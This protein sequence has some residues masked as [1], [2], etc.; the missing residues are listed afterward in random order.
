[1]SGPANGS[2]GVL[3]TNTGAVTYS[4]SNNFNGADSF[5]FTVFDGTL[6]ATGTVSLL[7]LPINDPPIA[8]N[9]TITVN[10]DSTNNIP[11]LVNDS[12]PDGNPLTIVSVTGTNG[13]ATVNGTNVTYIPSPNFF[14]TNVITYCI[15]DSFVTNCATI[16]V[17]VSPV[18]DAPESDNT[19]LWPLLPGYQL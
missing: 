6:Y 15:S 7:V 8:V 19:T 2:L 11:V 3:N 12:D 10:E 1:M 16:T 17:I 4:P 9:D 5:T 13:T 14:G 18:N